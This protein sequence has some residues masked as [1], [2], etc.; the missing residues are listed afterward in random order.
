MKHVVKHDLDV[1]VAKQATEKAI[2]AYKERFAQ[3]SPTF[4]WVTEHRGEL[5][6][7]AKG[8]KIKGAVELKPGA[9]EI[10]VDVPFLLRPFSGKAVEVIEREIQKWIAKAK[11]GELG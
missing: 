9:I 1:G 4:A 2:T 6:F 11:A 7:D 3:Y 8:A 5:G 10:D